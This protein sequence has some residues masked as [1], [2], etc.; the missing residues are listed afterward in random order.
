[1]G[2]SEW[3]HE[4]LINAKLKRKHDGINILTTTMYK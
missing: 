3:E 2:E 1:M 4:T